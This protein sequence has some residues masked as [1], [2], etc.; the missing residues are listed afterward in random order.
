MRS[1]HTW[2]GR[3]GGCLTLLV[4]VLMGRGQV[5][6]QSPTIPEGP[7]QAGAIAPGGTRSLLGT[8]PGSGGGSFSDQA[9]SAGQV[10]GGRPGTATPRVPTSVSTPG[11]DS[12]PTAR[13]TP[14]AV[15][16]LAP[17]TEVPLYGNLDLAPGADEGPENGL[18][19][20]AALDLMLRNNLDLI[21]RRFE[22]PAA[23]ADILTASLRANPIFYADSQLIPYGNYSA[24]RPGGQTQYDV[25]VS[26]PVDFSGKRKARTMV[27]VQAKKSTEAL[28]QD[29]V[30]LQIG[31]LATAYVAVLA[32]RETARYAASGLNG[33]GEALDATEKLFQRGNRTSADVDRLIAQRGAATVGLEDAEEAVRR[34]KRALGVILNIPPFEAETIE[35][36]ASLRDSAPPPPSGDELIAMALRCRPDLLAYRIGVPYAKASLEL[37]KANRYADAYVL[38]QP[39]TF[40]NNAPTHQK[41]AY[42]FAV[43]VTVPLPIHNRNQGNI[44]RARININQTQVQLDAFVRQVTNEVVQAEREYT[45]TRAYLT[46]LETNVLP[47]SQKVV[48]NTRR[49]L[50]AGELVEVTVLLNTQREANDIVRQFRDTAVRHRRS[51]FNLNTAV[52]QRILP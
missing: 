8:V 36:R 30:R 42:S 21:A 43:G 49:L 1:W 52:G 2:S 17:L 26:Y 39:Y 10:L 37:Q 38:L 29:A 51:M 28:F 31:N 40:Q 15:P 19:F 33:L 23:Q 9:V 3:I 6:A 48:A 50:T 25:N 41:S 12:T 20:D 32:A 45:T 44:E 11:S 46:R 18:T 13:P 14:L 22:I 5:R 4:L 47:T 16:A 27:A 7:V 35:L 24:T 34:A